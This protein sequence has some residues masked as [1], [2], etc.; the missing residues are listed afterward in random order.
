VPSF[1]AKNRPWQ[2]KKRVNC[3]TSGRKSQ[4]NQKIFK[5]FKKMLAKVT[6]TVIINDVIDALFFL[7]L[8]LGEMVV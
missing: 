3:G 7:C 5:I 4:K 2:A 6:S 1:P 8:G